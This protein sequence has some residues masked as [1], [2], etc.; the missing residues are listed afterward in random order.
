MINKIFKYSGLLGSLG[1][2]LTI[3]VFSVLS[4]NYSQL[5]QTIS[6]LNAKGVV[7]ATAMNICYSIAFLFL[8]I[9]ALYFISAKN[10]FAIISGILMIASVLLLISLNWFFPMD[11]WEGVR[12]LADNVHSNVV[13]LAVCVFLLSQIF[14]SI[15]FLRT[16]Q[17][18][19]KNITLL[20]FGISLFFGLLSLWSHIY[21]SEVI[22]IAER[23]WMVSFLSYIVI[24]ALNIS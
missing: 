24:I 7:N 19:M 16:R 9:F 2:L 17:L 10:D 18:K 14:A 22:N 23:G 8:I 21:Q 6:E 4:P 5:T 13:T 1:T 3:V 11:P 12:T 15:Y 20:L